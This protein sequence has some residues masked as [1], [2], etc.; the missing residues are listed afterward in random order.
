MIRELWKHPL[1]LVGGGVGDDVE[2]LRSEPEQQ[3]AHAAAH[4]IGGVTE[5]PQLFDDPHGVGID[6]IQRD[7][8]VR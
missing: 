2:V 5:A 1:D 7:F 4:Q 8:H 6:L 3:I